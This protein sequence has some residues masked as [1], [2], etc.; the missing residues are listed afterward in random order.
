MRFLVLSQYFP[1]EIG[2]P[3]VRLAAVTRELEKRSHQ[4]EVV[5]ALPNHPTGNIFP[6]YRHKFYVQEQRNGATVH[7]LWIY[8]ALGAGLK[9][10]LNYLSF[11]ITCL[12]GLLKASRPDYILVESPPLFLGIPAIIAA[13]LWRVP[14]IFNVA[15]LWPDSVRELGLIKNSQLLLWAERLE[16]WIYLN[17]TYVSSVTEGIR[18]R[19]IDEK[20]VNP[21]KILFLP[22]GVDT[23]L[24]RPMQP[25]PTLSE[26]IGLNTEEKIILYAGTHGF[27]HGLEVALRAAQLLGGEQIHMVFLGDGSEK[28][29]L[30]QMA[31][32]M[33]LSNVL[34]LHAAPPEH[35]V[36]LYSI[37]L[38][39]LS[40]L[41][42]SSLFESTRPAKVIAT[43]ACGKA[44]I[45]SG[46]GEGARLVEKARAGLVVPP[47]DPHALAAA[48]RRL[49]AD[50]DLAAQ[51]GQNGRRYVEAHLTW[52][53][54]V[55]NWLAQIEETE[56]SID[57]P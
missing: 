57:G 31:E 37:A 6:P 18:S 7:R 21:H 41:R 28:P 26:Q 38:A 30:I 2:A 11:S 51:L 29:M 56:V 34:F 36:H 27:A 23:E 15:D 52:S 24:F 5:T 54:L 25:D 43:M 4:I 33:K 55:E 47:Q 40:T 45:Y 3:Q 10:M 42:D 50:P 49:I 46:A 20:A 8:T 17:S 1:P 39:G 44:V 9:R 19:L 35:V 22:N 13:K 12:F 14:V 32:K 16:Q 53:A 48:I